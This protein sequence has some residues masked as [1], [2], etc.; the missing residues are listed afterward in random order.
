M[1]LLPLKII[2]SDYS[3]GQST[4]TMDQ[5]L[6]PLRDCSSAWGRTNLLAG[7]FELEKQGFK[8]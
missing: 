8:R 5:I 4:I 2:R 3:T 7:L 6:S 1:S